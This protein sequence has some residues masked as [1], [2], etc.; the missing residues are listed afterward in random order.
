MFPS[1]LTMLPLRTKGRLTSTPTAGLRKHLLSCWS[2]LS[3]RLPKYYRLLLVP[4]VIP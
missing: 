3:N 4:M 2:G 1:G